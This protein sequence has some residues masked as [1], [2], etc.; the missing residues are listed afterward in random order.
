MGYH[1]SHYLNWKVSV[2]MVLNLVI[3]FIGT[4]IST[5]GNQVYFMF[6]IGTVSI[7]KFY[8]IEKIRLKGLCLLLFTSLILIANMLISENY[9]AIINFAV[10]ILCLYILI[11]S[12]SWNIYRGIHSTFVFCA[13]MQLITA[14]L[15]HYVEFP[16]S[17]YYYEYQTIRPVFL[18]N[19]PI[20]AGIVYALCF[21]K[22]KDFYFQCIFI[23]ASL[24]TLS[25]FAIGYSLLCYLLKVRINILAIT[26]GIAVTLISAFFIGETI[27]MRITNIASLS[28]GSSNIRIAVALAQIHLLADNL[29]F[30]TGYGAVQNLENYFGFASDSYWM[31]E[32]KSQSFLLEILTSFG[33]LGSAGLLLTLVP[34]LKRLLLRS[35]RVSFLLLVLFVFN[36]TLFTAPMLLI[37]AYLSYD[38]IKFSLSEKVRVL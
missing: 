13:I 6:I 18:F 25:I 7:F 29:L 14:A 12:S 31:E 11:N 10:A 30:G 3:F 5:Y 35:G 4:F 17:K 37:L 2:F 21:Y 24:S 33:I 34:L 36:G 16:F 23:F 19:E 20:I 38:D 26:F 27:Y 15:S 28:D 32:V 1:K 9:L 22:S 8:K